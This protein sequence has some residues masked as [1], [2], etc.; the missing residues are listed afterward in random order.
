M[1]DLVEVIFKAVATEYWS[2]MGYSTRRMAEA[3]AIAA[4]HPDADFLS[5]ETIIVRNLQEPNF[6]IMANE[7]AEVLRGEFTVNGYRFSIG[8]IPSGEFEGKWVWSTTRDESAPFDEAWMA[9][10]DAIR[11][12]KQVQNDDEEA[13]GDAAE[14]ERYGTYAQQHWHDGRL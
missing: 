1:S 5:L 6:V 3:A 13:I 12:V 14:V 2:R 10:A 9:Q 11:Y 7:L 4:G 8:Q